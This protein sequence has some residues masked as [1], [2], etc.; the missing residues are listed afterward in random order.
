M[1]RA[2]GQPR[3]RR[4]Q[5]Q[6]G[7]ATRPRPVRRSGYQAGGHRVALDVTAQ[8]HQIAVAINQYR[9]EAPLE[10]MTDEAV[11]PIEGLGV[12]AVEVPHQPLQ[13]PQVRLHHQVITVAHQAIGQDIGVE[14]R[15]RLAKHVEPTLAASIVPVDRLATV[16]ARDE[17]IN[18]AWEFDAQGSGQG[19][20]DTGET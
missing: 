9:L 2:S 18:G 16:A 8:R 20:E 5:P 15:Q 3:R 17:V 6:V 19:G 13:L 11:A 12:N 10:Q 7:A 14:L 4:R 1:Q